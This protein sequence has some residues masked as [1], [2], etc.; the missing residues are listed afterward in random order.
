MQLFQHNA[1]VYIA[2]R[3]RTKFDELVEETQELSKIGALSVTS[4]SMEFLQL[5]LSD[6]K[7][8]IGAAG[9]FLDLEKRLDVIVA[10]AA[11]S[12][13]VSF[14]TSNP[15]GGI[16]LTSVFVVAMYTFQRWG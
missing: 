3:S 16:C 4:G 6:I 11:L 13:V 8:C 10:N 12:V 14:F 5:D 2:S 15:S 9:R 7:S 1:K